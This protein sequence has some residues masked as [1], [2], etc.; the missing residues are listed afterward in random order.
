MQLKSKFSFF[1]QQHLVYLDSAATSQVPDSVVGVVRQTLEYRGN[2]NRSA[3]KPAIH[4]SEILDQARASIASFINAKPDEIA[5]VSNTTDAIN[6]FVSSISH[7][8]K[9]G[10]EIV[11]T[12]AEHHSNL[13]PYIALQR[14]GAK[15]RI[16]GED[17]G[18][19][20][21]SV[22]QQTLNEHTKIVAINHISNVLG[23]ITPLTKIINLVRKHAPNA[24]VVV[25]GAQAVAHVPVDV[26]KIGCDVYAF[27]G[28]KMYG[29]DG[30]GVLYI[31]K[32]LHP[33]LR[34]VR[35]GGGNV[36]NVAV[37]KEK[38]YHIVSPDEV[39]GMAMFEG[40][41]A[42]LANIVG[43]SRAVQFIRGIGYDELQKND[44]FLMRRLLS[45]LKEIDDVVIFG[46]AKASERASLVTFGVRTGSIKE[47]GDA[48]G[49]RNICV[50]YGSFCAFP[51]MGRLGSEGVR[52]SFGC[53]N[54]ENDVDTVLE[55]I[56][57]Y[58]D[59]KHGRILNPNLERFRNQPYYRNVL[60]LN[61][62]QGLID[63]VMDAVIQPEDTEVVVMAGHFLGIPDEQENRFWP[64][65]KSMI[66]D[67]LQGYLHEFGMTSFPLFTWELGTKLVTALRERNINT[68]LSIIGNDTTGINELRLSSSNTTQKTA[69][70]YRDEL[71]SSFDNSVPSIYAIAMKTRRLK[72]TDILRHQ[73]S[74]IFRESLLREQFK[75]FVQDKK[76]AQ[77]FDG[78]ITYTGVGADEAKFELKIDVLDNPEY[79]T[80][81]FDTFNSKTGGKY[82]TAE[83]AQYLAE[84]FGTATPESFGYLSQ[85]VQQ[86]K[87]K[88]KHTV[89]VI[90][91]PMMCDDAIT[92]GA[93]LYIKL[94]LQGK[95]EGSFKFFNVPFGPE[96]ARS[97]A[98]GI[99]V[100]YLSDK[101]RLETIAVDEEPKFAELW[102]LC[103]DKLLYSPQ[104]YFEEMERLFKRIGINKSSRLLDT[105]VGPGFFDIDLLRQGYNV[106]T[107]DKSSEMIEPFVRELREANIQHQTTISTWLD[108]PKHFQNESFDMLFNR[109]NTLIYA[110][111]GWNERKVVNQKS[112]IDVLR[113]TL[114]VYYDLLKPGGYLYVDK[115]R[116]D[117]VPAKKVVARLD[118][119]KKESE[120]IVFYVE[121]KPENNIR[122]AQMLLR[123][124]KG[125]EE[126]LPNMAYDLSEDELETLLHDVGFKKVERL[127]LASERHFVVWL[128]QK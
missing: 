4:N 100:K 74:R 71:L 108:L 72:D 102:R 92:R 20:S 52:V 27:S 14:S 79:K 26:R 112:A 13:L 44:T 106:T 40:G 54:D 15:I 103:E 113:K 118:I 24:M 43:L 75:R 59:K 5:F 98:N 87:V 105:C 35:I 69:E 22:F 86:P 10:D 91:T 121:R 116:D 56:R 32:R 61:S 11:V 18:S 122:F 77:L 81:S 70:Q 123:N 76:N 127:L 90:L 78:V 83:I 29:P 66:P 19:F 8:I 17:D 1:R 65:I 107:A 21:L 34:I 96:S 120:D 80:C 38:T 16:V 33:T 48:L 111:G 95:N 126:G 97:L 55:E 73:G 125:K 51:L 104:A 119:T 30:I 6:S 94:F 63:A 25:D 45:G 49:R 128:A 85:R 93:E 9:K 101:D 68:T 84:L 99:E 47:L 31:S 109:G 115:F 12:I 2:P 53:Y 124:S 39:G 28:H 58:F 42:N 60:V 7:Q 3:H 57:R 114:K 67:R 37:T 36:K 82:C 89:M 64:S 62:T 110:A 23:T 41:T 46:P 88:A 117:E 50:R